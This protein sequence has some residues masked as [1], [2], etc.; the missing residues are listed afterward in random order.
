MCFVKFDTQTSFISRIF[1]LERFSSHYLHK[2][3]QTVVVPT[4]VVYGMRVVR[5]GCFSYDT[6][7]LTMSCFAD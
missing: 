6:S 4:V 1:L 3:L 2:L 7:E 5:V